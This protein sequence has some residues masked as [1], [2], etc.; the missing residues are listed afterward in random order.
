VSDLYAL[1]WRQG[2][3]LDTLLEVTVLE[4]GEDGLTSSTTSFARW[5]VCTQDCDLASAPADSNDA[6]VELRPV[7]QQNA[8]TDWGIRS[9]RF[10]LAEDAYVDAALP[11]CFITPK[12]LTY[13]VGATLVEIE[14]VRARAFTTWLGKRYDRPAVPEHLVQIAREVAS[15]CGTKG[16]RQ[17]AAG[18]H[19]VLMQFDD[20][21]DPPRVAL[22][23]VI[24]D[25]ADPNEVRE[26]LAAASTRV[27]TELGVVAAIE[28]GTRAE[29]SLELLES[30]YSADL[31]QLTWRD[32]EPFGAE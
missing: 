11:R 18:V 26:W 4:G 31:S 9:Q 19:D 30:S 10:L 25:A 32:K 15:R 14:P 16:G 23:A 29:T 5:V 28:V 17:T 1:G 2:S 8:P 12:A 13:S 6:L 20:S 21:T 7:L 22:F 24:H 3:I 27:R